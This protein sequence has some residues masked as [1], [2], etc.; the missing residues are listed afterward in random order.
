[1][2]AWS[3]ILLF[4]TVLVSCAHED[5]KDEPKL[6][7]PTQN[8]VVKG[9][10]SIEAKQVAAEEQA[11]F[12][13]EVKFAKN[14][15][16]LPAAAKLKI[17][18]LVQQANSA[19]KLSRVQVAV[20]ADQ[21]YPSVH[22]KALSSDQVELVKRRGQ[23]VSSVIEAVEKDADPEVHNMAER[24]GMWGEL[25]SN[26][27]AR[28]KKAFEVAGIPNTDTSV[29]SPSKASHAIVLISVEEPKKE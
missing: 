11:A 9:V 16:K 22:T 2:K 17:K 15:H 4:C 29:K 7:E 25:V 18:K 26:A 20:W 13:V 8:A 27:G 19:G 5:K 28:L 24:P 3:T 10:P 12:V 14:Q 1:V 23:E 21:E 6:G